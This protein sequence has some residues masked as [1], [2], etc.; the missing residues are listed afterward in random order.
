MRLVRLAEFLWCGLDLGACGPWRF[1]SIEPTKWSPVASSQTVD[2]A[3]RCRVSNTVL[4]ALWRNA[5]SFWRLSYLNEPTNRHENAGT[6]RE[7]CDCSICW[8]LTP[9]THRRQRHIRASAGDEQKH[10]DGPTKLH[11][12][13]RSAAARSIIQV[14][15]LAIRRHVSRKR[16]EVTP[17]VDH[18][19]ARRR[20]RI[21]NDNEN[22][23]SPF[24]H[25]TGCPTG[26]T[27]EQPVVK[28]VW[29]RV[30]Q[31]VIWCKR[32]LTKTW[33]DNYGK[34]PIHFRRLNHHW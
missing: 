33:N 4:F 3:T 8:S 6:V 34:E 13:R 15:Q 17:C 11:V 24:T 22:C 20:R 18:V 14:S 23:K 31:R 12:A 27:I 1:R 10:S 19:I 5:F 21:V 2:T 16:A 9:L 25:T 26:C 7:L 28:P 30:W 29:Q 32:G